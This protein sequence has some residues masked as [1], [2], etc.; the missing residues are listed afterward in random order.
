M[1]VITAEH[2]DTVEAESPKRRAILEAAGRLFMTEGY[3]AVSMDAVARAAGVSKATLYAHFGAKDRLF[4]AI[5]HEACETMRRTSGVEGALGDMPLRDALRS[6]G[7]QWLRFLLAEQAIAVR[8]VVVAKGPKFPELA[9]AFF[10]NGPRLSR[11]W[12]AGWI[13]DEVAR[14]RLRCPDA[15]RAAEQ[16]VSLLT[17][18]LT[19]RVTLGLGGPPDDAVITQQVESTVDMFCRAYAPD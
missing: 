19:L 18:E 3:G 14:G 17:G 6:L 15:E 2:P 10:E 4:A 1:G 7:G 12:I 16:F 5:I 8:R 11:A 9:H 13:A